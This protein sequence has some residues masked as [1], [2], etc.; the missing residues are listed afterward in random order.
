MK[1]QSPTPNYDV[2]KVKA[3]KN[4]CLST[5]SSRMCVGGNA[6]GQHGIHV[7]RVVVVLAFRP[8]VGPTQ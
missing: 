1:M 7:A 2:I 5:M 4:P 6:M 8:V 3:L